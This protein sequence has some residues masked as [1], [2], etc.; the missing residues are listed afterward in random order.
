[1]LTNGV[2]FVPVV[3]SIDVPVLLG[4]ISREGLTELIHAHGSPRA[5]LQRQQTAR[6]SVMSDSRL[7]RSLS[8]STPSKDLS[9]E[10]LRELAKPLLKDVHSVPRAEEE[11]D[12]LHDE[13]GMLRF[14]AHLSLH[15]AHPC[16]LQ[17]SS[18]HTH[19]L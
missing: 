12:L 3:R 13:K 9:E 4:V 14:G 1:M 7:N 6:F 18:L 17:L 2:S 15:N 5:K 8:T 16:S 19:T 11:M 10:L